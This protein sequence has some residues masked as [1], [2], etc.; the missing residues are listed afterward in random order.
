MYRIECVEEVLHLHSAL[1]VVEPYEK[2]I[3]ESDALEQIH[4][5]ESGN[6]PDKAILVGISESVDS[7]YRKDSPPAVIGA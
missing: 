5:G 4:N 3:K 1:S 2:E 7:N 6:A